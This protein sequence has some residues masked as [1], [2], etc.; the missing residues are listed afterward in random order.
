MRLGSSH[1]A[2]QRLRL[3]QDIAARLGAEM[4]LR[5]ILAE[6]AGILRERFDWDYVGCAHV[7]VD[8]GLV[9]YAAHACASEVPFADALT[10]PVGE[11]IIGQVAASGISC[12]VDDVL[13][14]DNYICMIG[15]TRSELCVPVLSQGETIAV[16]DAQSSRPAAF[17]D[18]DVATLNLVAELLAGRMAAARQLEATRQRAELIE[19]LADVARAM[20]GEDELSAMLQRLIE[21]LHRRLDLTLSTLCLLRGDSDQLVLHASAGESSYPLV[22]GE[23]WPAS[24][25]VTGRALRGQVRVFVPDVR[26]DLDYI[27]G[28]P[29]SVAELVVPIRFRGEPLG[30]INLESATPAAFSPANQIAVQALADQAAGA[31]RLALT[32]QRL[33]EVNAAAGTVAAELAATNQ[34]LQRANA[35]LGALSLRDPLTGLGNRRCFDRTLQ[36]AW[37]D[38]QRSREP[39]ALLLVDI[40]HY[41]A[42]NDRYGH[43]EGDQCLQRLGRLMQRLVARRRVVAARYG[44]EEFALVVPGADRRRAVALA[45]RMHAALAGLQLPHAAS[46]TAPVLTI[47]IGVAVHR[48]DT[49]REPGDLLRDAD[50]ALYAAKRDGRNRTVVAS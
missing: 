46:P 20:L 17:S 4:S 34:R 19:L 33:E 26:K 29:R 7:D 42:F 27:E 21:E 18:E 5:Q 41:K 38:C 2:E 43:A 39:L 23:A 8:D 45:E 22:H 24:R 10:Q 35:K 31:I 13:Q 3:M 1:S 36:G 15:A 50:L 6:V 44:G 47:S 28:N 40:D 16:L 25:G 32:K 30:L 48:P 11:G 14:H 9:R 49:L 37:R 12:R